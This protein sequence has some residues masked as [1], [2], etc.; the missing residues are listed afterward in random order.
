MYPLIKIMYFYKRSWMYEKYPASI[1]PPR[2]FPPSDNEDT[3]LNY[4]QMVLD[5]FAINTF[6]LSVEVAAVPTTAGLTVSAP[7]APFGRRAPVDQRPILK[8]AKVA[9]KAPAN[10]WSQQVLRIRKDQ[11]INDFEIKVIQALA[12]KFGYDVSVVA[13]D[14]FNQIDVV[15]VIAIRKA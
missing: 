15:H 7:S 6:C 9:L 1:L 11:P 2:S 5:V 10:L 4:M 14:I 8:L 13:T 3:L 12:R